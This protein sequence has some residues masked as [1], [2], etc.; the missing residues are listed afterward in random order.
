MNEKRHC[1]VRQNTRKITGA[2]GIIPKKNKC[3]LKNTSLTIAAAVGAG[4]INENSESTMPPVSG[5][6]F[7]VD[8]TC[9]GCTGASSCTTDVCISV[10]KVSVLC[11]F[12][13]H[14]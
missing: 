4:A 11:N 12:G 2:E 13:K 7:F 14:I 3:L 6:V 5:T 9:P 10:L 1:L 8:C